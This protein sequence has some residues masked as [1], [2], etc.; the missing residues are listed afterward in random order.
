[1]VYLDQPDVGEGGWRAARVVGS[2]HV[3]APRPLSAVS[4]ETRV[5]IAV[6]LSRARELVAPDLLPVLPSKAELLAVHAHRDAV[7]EHANV[8][9]RRCAW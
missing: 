3:E 7:A 6:L 5:A 8:E 2:Q 4:E 9:R 1:V